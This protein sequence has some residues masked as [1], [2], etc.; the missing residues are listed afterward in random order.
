MSVIDSPY[1]RT[2][3]F[4][5]VGFYRPGR[6][7]VRELTGF[8]NSDPN[9]GEVYPSM[10]RQSEM[11]ACDIHNILKQFSQQGFEALVREKA[12][13]GQYADL[14]DEIDYQTS[15]NTVL[16]AQAS[17]ATLPSQV[18]ERFANDPARFLEF[19]ADPK[20][21]DDAIR[22]GLVE[23]PPPEPAPT[24]VEVVNAADSAKS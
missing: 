3:E 9:T 8:D 20:N 10:T 2:V 24:R 16:A 23:A 4:N 18:R 13:T 11:D 19:L 1:G 21:R 7:T 14:P 6:E 15:L 17:F 12:A 22:M 5:K